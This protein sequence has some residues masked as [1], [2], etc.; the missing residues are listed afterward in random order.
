MKKKTGRPKGSKTRTYDVVT[1]IPPKCRKCGSTELSAVP[2]AQ[3]IV[4]DICGTIHG[5]SYD[6]VIWRRKQCVCGQLVE[7][8]TYE[9]KTTA[10]SFGDGTGDQKAG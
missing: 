9:K 8:R 2:G 7:V 10:N 3:P 4:R 6:R 1:H 5:D